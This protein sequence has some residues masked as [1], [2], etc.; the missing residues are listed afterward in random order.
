MKS[1][2]IT[3]LTWAI[4]FALLWYGAHELFYPPGD[5]IGAL[6]VSFFGAIG[7]GGLRKAR[8]ERRDTRIIART[9]GKPPL[10]GRASRSPARSSPWGRCWM[11]R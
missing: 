7:I 8:I 5:W 2:G 1:F 6:V 11:A 10:D 9:A 4:L 3:L